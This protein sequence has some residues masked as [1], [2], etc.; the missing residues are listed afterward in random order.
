ML[1]KLEV[2]MYAYSKKDRDYGIGKIINITEFGQDFQGDLIDVK[3]KH[4][5]HAIPN[6]EVV[7]SYNI[8]DLLKVGD[9]VNGEFVIQVSK[10]HGWVFTDLTY[11]NERKC[12]ECHNCFTDKEIKSV[13]TKEQF[14]SMKYEVE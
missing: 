8:V 2:G 9:Y 6:Q 1:N 5:T 14:E 4:S 12:E 10:E 13:A 3:F 11:Y 7:A